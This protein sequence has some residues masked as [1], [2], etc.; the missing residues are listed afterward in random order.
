MSFITTIKN[1]VQANNI[2]ERA[3]EDG[4]YVGR[5]Y[6][7]QNVDPREIEHY[8]NVYPGFLFA[9]AYDTAYMQ[10]VAAGTKHVQ[11]QEEM[12]A[13]NIAHYSR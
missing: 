8:K 10:G 5:N 11:Q 13:A 1:R 3:Y 7:G 9:D 2:A 12:R 6:Y 4:E